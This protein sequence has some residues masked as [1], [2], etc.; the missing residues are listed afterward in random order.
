MNTSNYRWHQREHDRAQ[1][2]YEQ[3]QLHREEMFAVYMKRLQKIEEIRDLMEDCICR[4]NVLYV[5]TTPF[6]MRNGKLNQPHEHLRSWV[7]T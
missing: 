6:T 3:E 2:E 1:E 7:L 5:D 4:I